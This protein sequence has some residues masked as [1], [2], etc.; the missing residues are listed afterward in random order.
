METLQRGQSFHDRW[1]RVSTTSQYFCFPDV[2]KTSEKM[3]KLTFKII[4]WSALLTRVCFAKLWKIM[5]QSK[6]P[7]IAILSVSYFVWLWF[8]KRWIVP[9]TA[10]SWTPHTAK[11][12]K[13]FFTEN[14]WHVFQWPANFPHLTITENAWHAFPNVTINRVNEIDRTKRL[15]SFPFCI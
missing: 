2:T 11:H 1:E 12:T 8:D 4:V 15:N 13:Q 6:V 3:Q 7:R 5:E 9:G 10:G 14:N